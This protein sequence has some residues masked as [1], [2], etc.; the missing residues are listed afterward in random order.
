MENGDGDKEKVSERWGLHRSELR[1]ESAVDRP[2]HWDLFPTDRG[3]L[4]AVPSSHDGHA[5]CKVSPQQNGR[6]QQVQG[7][8]LPA[9]SQTLGVHQCVWLVGIPSITWFYSWTCSNG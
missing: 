4:P 8:C 6:T 5:P 1:A 7:E 9:P 2:S 3:A